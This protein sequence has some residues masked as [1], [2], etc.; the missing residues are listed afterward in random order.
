MSTAAVAQTTEPQNQTSG[1]SNTG[2]PAKGQSNATSGEQNATGMQ[3]NSNA[4]NTAQGK[5]AAKDRKAHKADKNKMDCTQAHT[6][7]NATTPATTRADCDN[8][9]KMQR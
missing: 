2:T 8:T 9:T 7:G 3:N 6:D 1:T 5:M 4:Q